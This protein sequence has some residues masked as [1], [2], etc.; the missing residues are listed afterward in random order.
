MRLLIMVSV[1][2]A[3]GTV[4]HGAPPQPSDS[5]KP[6]S[7][8]PDSA[9]P[10]SAKPD[11]AK[12]DSAKPD[13]AK[14]DAAKPDAAKDP[15][16]APRFGLSGMAGSAAAKSAEQPVP[17]GAQRL[18]LT[19]ARLFGKGQV[20]DKPDRRGAEKRSGFSLGDDRDWKVQAAQVGVM[21]AGFAAL[22]G[23]CGGG[24][25]M[26]PDVPFLPQSEEGPPPG[27]E[28]RP[29]SEPRSAR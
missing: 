11:S 15:G 14:P 20:K 10:D 19:P 6:D 7:A 1:V 9:K 23:L 16:T 4:A 22:V 28:I 29:N 5:A 25:C 13:S 26:L 17:V 21:A 2:V 3:A 27:L 24:K 12:P 18:D 8:K